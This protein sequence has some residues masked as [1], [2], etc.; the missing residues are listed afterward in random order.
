LTRSKSRALFS[1]HNL[2][3]VD[4]VEDWHDEANDDDRR[5]AQQWLEDN[6]SVL[7][8]PTQ[9]QVLKELTILSVAT[10]MKDG[11]TEALKALVAVYTLSFA[12][13]PASIFA[14]ACQRYPLDEGNVW[15]PKVAELMS[16]CRRAGGREL[17]TI[18]RMRR[19]A[20]GPSS[21][22][23]L[24]SPLPFRRMA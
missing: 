6:A 17:R 24:T 7:A 1:E 3:G 14:A 20:A 2:Y 16:A 4:F 21:R 19:I 11:T 23:A 13:V 12:A 9:Q 10:Q 5:S 8:G 18:E 15:F 22:S